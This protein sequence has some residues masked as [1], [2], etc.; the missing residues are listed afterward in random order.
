MRIFLFF[1]LIKFKILPPIIFTRP[2]IS[3]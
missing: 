3:S 1:F 2:Y